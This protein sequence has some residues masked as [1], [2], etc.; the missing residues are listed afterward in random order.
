MCARSGCIRNVWQAP[1]MHTDV[2]MSMCVKSEC[3][4]NR[5]SVYRGCLHGLCIPAVYTCVYVCKIGMYKK[6]I[7][8]TK[9]AYPHL[10]TC[11]CEKS[12]C[13]GNRSPLFRG[14]LQGHST[15]AVYTCVYERKVGM[16]KKCVAGTK[17]AYWCTYEYVREVRLCR[18]Q[19]IRV[20]RV[21]AGHC[22]TAVYVCI[23][24]QDRDV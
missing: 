15:P 10:R 19:V 1:S 8:S 7:A 18:K 21:L 17:H 22:A 20:Q 3:V 14:C 2:H 12:E 6:C 16:Y 24:V 9:H 13:V 23:C 4:G 11:M 5:S